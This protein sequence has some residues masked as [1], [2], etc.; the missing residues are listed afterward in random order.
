[1]FD[2]KAYQ[3][4]VLKPLSTNAAQQSAI[5]GAL[6]ALSGAQDETTVIEALCK[7]DIAALFAITPGMS[8]NELTKHVQGLERHLNAARVPVAKLVKQ[9]LAA[10]NKVLEQHVC[11]PEFWEELSHCAAEIG[12]AELN[13]FAQA[14][15]QDNPLAVVTAEQLR[16]AASAYG[17]A[18]SVTDAELAGAVKGQG[19]RVCP[20]F[21]VPVSKA[22]NAWSKGNLPPGMTNIVEVLLLHERSEHPRDIRVIDELSAVVAGNRRRVVGIAD[23]RQSKS[24][25]NTR[26]GDSM[27]SAKKVLTKIGEECTTD[28]DVRDLILAWWANLAEQLVRTQG[29]TPT[30]AL[31]RLMAIG[32]A[33]LDA[34][35]LLAGVATG[36]SGPDIANVKDL[37]AAGDLSG[38]RRLYLALVGG[39]EDKAQSPIAR[40][41]A[42]ALTAAE[43]RKSAAMEAYRQAIAVKDLSGARAALGDA[44][45]VDHE[46]TEITRL[47]SQI[48][49]D[50]PTGLDVSYSPSRKGVALAWRGAQDPDIRYTVVRSE[51][52]TPANPKV[53]LT[54][55]A[56][57]ADQAAFDPSPLVAHQ[58]VYAV[59][60]FRQ[61]ASYSAPAVSRITVL[62]PPSDARTVVT[63]DDVTVFWQAPAQVAGVSGELISAD[64]TR[65]AFPTTTQGR[66]RIEGLQLGQKYTV[67][68]RAHYVVNGQSVLSESTTLDATPRGTVHAVRDLSIGST[69]MPDGK[70]GVRAEWTEVP[71]YAT[72]LWSLPIDMAVETGA[73]VTADRLDVL[74]GKRVMGAIR[75]SGVRQTMDFYVL[76]DV[77]SFVPVTWDGTEGIVGGAV[78]AGAAPP[79]RD[80]EAVRLGS[81]LNVSWVWPHGDYLMDVTWSAVNG[82]CGHKRVDRFVY[83]RDGG[84][85]IP[86]AELITE[87]SV[88][89]VVP[90]LGKEH[91]FAPVTVRLK[92]V[93]PSIRYQ[94]KLPRGPFGGREARVSVTSD[95][96]RGEADLV[97]VMAAGAFMPS[98]PEDGQQIASLHFDFSTDLTHYRSF[99][100]PKIKGGYWVRLFADS[101]SP[102]ILNDPSTSSMKG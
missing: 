71:G 9:L 55:A 99:S 44:R 10:V 39:D 51:S 18:A 42:E 101:A 68:L 94:L 65:R 70:P 62:P 85:R 96:F 77:R 34:R 67:V 49:P 98:R 60:A 14:V 33:D 31:N 46:D 48:P 87:V 23:L 81:E 3:D 76:P 26:S 6:R 4:S 37:I 21:E 50:Q 92:A 8:K 53:G 36:G 24:A 69:R 61:G 90:S 64:G 74:T 91:T 72:E 54:I 89:T 13:D 84:V 2:K 5:N 40:E 82:K 22:A 95:G 12:Q 43:E 27:E 79:P 100:I 63:S 80:V 15:K 83:R 59:F 47:L 16:Q 86:N 88:G 78:V 38:A 57:T 11:D 32:L 58:A 97:A 75:S 73:R 102:I 45:S 56:A 25:V 19:V 28:S 20:D 30:L 66:L 93:P 7:A 1:M 35:R 52:G 41:A 17:I 29:L